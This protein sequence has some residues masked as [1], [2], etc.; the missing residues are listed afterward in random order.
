M[1]ESYEEIL[2]LT[3][4][5]L[6]LWYAGRVVSGLGFSSIPAEIAVGIVFG[7]HGANLISEFS[8]EYAPLQ[9]LGFIGVSFVIFNSGM[10]LNVNKLVSVDIGLTAAGVAALGTLLPIALGILFFYILGFDAYPVSHITVDPICPS[11]HNLL[12]RTGSRLDSV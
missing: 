4:Y 2:R 3:A 11:T 10:H 1:S 12:C 9:L 5:L 6:C 8:E 7:G